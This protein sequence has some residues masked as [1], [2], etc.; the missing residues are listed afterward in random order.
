MGMHGARLE[1]SHTLWFDFTTCFLKLYNR[2]AFFFGGGH[3]SATM[4]SPPVFTF[5]RP[6]GIQMIWAGNGN[7]ILFGQVLWN[8]T[9]M[10]EERERIGRVGL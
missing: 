1:G 8:L 7:S 6:E 2:V 5:F 10:V 4:R 3:G 9:T